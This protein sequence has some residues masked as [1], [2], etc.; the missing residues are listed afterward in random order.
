MDLDPAGQIACLNEIIDTFD[1]ITE[2]YDVFKVETKADASYM[3]V[4]GLSD[5][6]N[7]AS[8]EV[9]I[10]VSYSNYNFALLDFF[11][12][13]QLNVMVHSM[14]LK[15]MKIQRLIKIRNNIIKQRSSLY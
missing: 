2:E 6:S 12:F 14:N 10:I 4:A 13:R 15:K 9:N 3:V 7:V 5:R 1:R 11:D 8:M